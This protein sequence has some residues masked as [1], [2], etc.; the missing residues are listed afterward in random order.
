[1][2]V[3][4]MTTVEKIRFLNEE[5]SIP[6]QALAEWTGCHKMTLR[7]YLTGKSTPTARIQNLMEQAIA[8]IL[9][10]IKD[11]LDS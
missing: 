9:Q 5:L 7:N 10:E 6:L 11:N 1:M 3:S 8:E 2:E 4:S